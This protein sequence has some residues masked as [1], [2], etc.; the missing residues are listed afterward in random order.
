MVKP[1]SYGV[2][3]NSSGVLTDHHLEPG[4]D[5]SPPPLRNGRETPTYALWPESST[6]KDLQCTDLKQAKIDYKHGANEE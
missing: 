5:F 4:A 3:R 2:I 1:Q 6:M